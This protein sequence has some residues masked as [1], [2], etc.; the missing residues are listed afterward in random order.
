MRDT[1]G[2]T[3][4]AARCV[5]AH[6]HR[7]FLTGTTQLQLVRRMHHGTLV[8][9]VLK[10]ARGELI[11]EQAIQ[12]IVNHLRHLARQHRREVIADGHT[13]D[14]GR[15]SM[16]NL[17]GVASSQRHSF[18]TLLI[19][20]PAKHLCHFQHLRILLLQTH[21]EPD[22]LKLQHIPYTTHQSPALLKFIVAHSMLSHI[23][24]HYRE[25]L[26]E[27]LLLTR[28]ELVDVVLLN[29]SQF[30]RVGHASHPHELQTIVDSCAESPFHV[31]AKDFLYTIGMCR[32]MQ[33]HRYSS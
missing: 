30:V 14:I 18:A 10:I 25:I 32:E 4:H 16:L 13:L 31:V 28:Q 9:E 24:R 21:D 19:S 33:V 26:V 17:H 29:L 27:Q 11:D 23:F 6:H 15:S 20:Y 3:C 12:V 1:F 2:L 7:S 22:A 8:A 5:E